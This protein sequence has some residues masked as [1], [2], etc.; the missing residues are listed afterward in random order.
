MQYFKPDTIFVGYGLL[1]EV[2]TLI[3]SSWTTPTGYLY[4][5]P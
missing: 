5:L 2:K 4:E 3:P 1:P